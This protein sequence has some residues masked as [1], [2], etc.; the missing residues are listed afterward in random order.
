PGNGPGRGDDAAGDQTLTAFVFAGEDK[1]LI[2]FSDLLASV[3]GLLLAERERLGRRIADLRFNREHVVSRIEP[4][5]AASPHKISRAFQN[6]W[7]KK[8]WQ[9]LQSVS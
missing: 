7:E 5:T 1:D 2:T 4:E 6:A 3:H 8:E 9:R